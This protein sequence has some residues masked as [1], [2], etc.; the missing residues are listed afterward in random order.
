MTSCPDITEIE[1]LGCRFARL[2]EAAACDWVIERAG[3]RVF[4]YVVTPN[5][6]HVVRLDRERRGAG[7]EG[8]R[9][10]YDDADL[11]LCDSRILALLARRSG[12][13]L[14]VVTGSDLTARLLSTPLPA[15]TRIALVGGN[16][17]QRDWL[18][19][20]QPQA[21]LF[22]HRPPMGLRTNLTA[23]T[24]AAAFVEDVLPSITLFTVGAP[25]SEI[26]AHLI[27]SRG[28]A[29]GVALCVGASL[30]FLSGEKRRAPRVLQATRL[31]WLFRLANEPRRLWRRYL[32]EGPAIFRIWH[33]WR[34]ARGD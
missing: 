12:I 14:P 28:R 9:H 33:R 16:D 6:D 3:G 26:V 29:R 10:A 27:K 8:L 20:A 17:R 25:Q 21:E 32:V 11:C 19:K 2:D 18:A 31:E 7:P 24:D 1:F 4:S 30:E 23:Q 34:R 22:H 5:V 15:G 13:R